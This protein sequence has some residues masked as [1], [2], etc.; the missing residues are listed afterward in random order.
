MNYTRIHHLIIILISFGFFLVWSPS[1]ATT[2]G[3][4]ITCFVLFCLMTFVSG[5]LERPLKTFNW[6]LLWV[7]VCPYHFIQFL[8]SID[9]FAL[10]L[11]LLFALPSAYN[12]HTTRTT[13]TIDVALHAQLDFYRPHNAWIGLPYTHYFYT[14]THFSSPLFVHLSCMVSVVLVVVVVFGRCRCT[15]VYS[16]CICVWCTMNICSHIIII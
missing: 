13:T 5:V 14:Y 6:L 2:Y 7:F 8:N 12:Q 3:W 10:A 15:I 16:V 1:S 4:C 11:L 9:G